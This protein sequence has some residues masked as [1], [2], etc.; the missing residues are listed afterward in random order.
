MRLNKLHLK[1]YRNYDELTID[2]SKN[3]IIFLG[4]NAQGKTNL[5]ESIY[6]LAMTRSH[7]TTS[8]Q[9]LIGWE[10]EQALVQGE[11]SKGSSKLPLE[12]LLS[13]KGRKTK[14]NHIEQKN[15]RS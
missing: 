14:I 1:N 8:E 11:I 3:L 7:R 13:K 2:F 9:E 12:I 6:V 10:Q 4:E 15:L 5:L